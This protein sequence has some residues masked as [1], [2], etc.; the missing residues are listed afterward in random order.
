M[1]TLD[2]LQ[3]VSDWQRGGGPSQKVER[4]ERL[5]AEAAK[6]PPTF[7][8]PGL[9]C[10][11]QISLEKTPL[12]E[13]MDT[14]SLPETIS[15]WTKDPSAAKQF[16]GGVPPVGWQGVIFAVPPTRGSVVV[17][18]DK[19]YRDDSFRQALEASKDKVDRYSEGAGRYLGLQREVVLEIS[20]VS[21]DDLYA[22]GGYSSDIDT[23]GQLWLGRLPTEEEKVFMVSTLADAGQA[24]GP[25][26]LEAPGKDRVILK[27]QGGEMPRLRHIKQL[28]QAALKS[29]R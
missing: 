27:V 26:W 2:F 21:L 10:F 15:A 11:R 3:A 22:L 5:K 20:E 1:F 23:L 14:L 29:P 12:F 9:C 25:Y 13:L 4:G 8:S 6:L 19:L 24:V 17:D 28:Q 18:L 7:R 16:K